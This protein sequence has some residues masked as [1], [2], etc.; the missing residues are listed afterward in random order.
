MSKKNL[1]IVAQKLRINKTD[2][3]RKLWNY[4]RN[5]QI[6]NLKFRRQQPIGNYIADFFSPENKLIIEVDAGQ[7]FE[8]EKDTERDKWF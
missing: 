8:S 3:E 2:A 5:K 6:L 4:L 1:T 7:H